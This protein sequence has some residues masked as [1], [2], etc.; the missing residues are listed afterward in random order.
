MS[1]GAFA[2]IRETTPHP[3]GRHG[4]TH[5]FGESMDRRMALGQPSLMLKLEV[6]DCQILFPCPRFKVD[7]ISWTVLEQC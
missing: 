7:P 4:A 2:L 5:G 3:D 1:A 6:Q